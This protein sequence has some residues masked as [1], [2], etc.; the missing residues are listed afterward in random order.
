MKLISIEVVPDTKR[1][2]ADE[3]STYTLELTY[4]GW[5]NTKKVRMAPT[6]VGN[7]HKYSGALRYS[8]FAD[9]FGNEASRALNT[10][11][12]NFCRIYTDENFITSTSK[13]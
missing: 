4:K 9:E 13:G 10:Q 1:D 11:L 7:Y 2:Y 5:F 12:T 8:C 6:G 3:Q